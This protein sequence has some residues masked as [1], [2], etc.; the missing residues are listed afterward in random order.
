M[1]GKIGR[2]FTAC[3]GGGKALVSSRKSQ[4]SAEGTIQFR[5]RAKMMDRE[6]CDSASVAS[7]SAVVD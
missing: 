1:S 2:E 3:T 7:S 6:A 5:K 4:H